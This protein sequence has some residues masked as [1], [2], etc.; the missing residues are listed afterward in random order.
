MQI[1][2][3]RTTGWGYGFRACALAHASRNDEVRLLGFARNDENGVALLTAVNSRASH[4]TTRTCPTSACNCLR[5]PAPERAG[6]RG[7]GSLAFSLGLSPPFFL[8]Q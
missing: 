2:E 3:S 6:L 1:R 7:R 4:P 5:S 8:V